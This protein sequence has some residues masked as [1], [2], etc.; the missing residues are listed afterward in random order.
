MTSQKRG[1]YFHR[2]GN[3]EK[4]KETLP[5]EKHPFEKGGSYYHKRIY[6]RL[7]N[8]REKP[9][10]NM[11]L[12]VYN[13][14]NHWSRGFSSVLVWMKVLV[15]CVSVCVFMCFYVIKS[16]MYRV[17][18]FW[19]FFSAMA[20]S[21]SAL[22]WKLTTASPDGRPSLLRWIWMHSGVNCNENRQSLLLNIC[23]VSDRQHNVLIKQVGIERKAKLRKSTTPL[24]TRSKDTSTTG[25]ISIN[26]NHYENI[27]TW[28]SRHY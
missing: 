2:L 22:F 25:V 8:D 26:N 28:A 7:E 4:R 17:P 20:L 5:G 15:V 19:R 13:I 11:L 18:I 27:R 6:C 9:V 12:A 14:L 1:G 10:K 3:E 24:D 16:S 21:A 23:L